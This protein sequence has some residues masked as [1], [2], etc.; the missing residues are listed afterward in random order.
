MSQ[1]I[2]LLNPAFRKVF[3]WLTAT[4][5]A[6]ATGLLLVI[7]GGATALATMRA[8]RQEQA[9]SERAKT[10]KDTQDRLVA[11]GKAVA[12]SKPNAELANELSSTLAFLKSREE[13]MKV[14]E[15]G[16][17]GSTTGFTEFLRGF[18]RQTPTGLWLTGFTIGAAGSDMEIRGRMT[19]P[20][21]LPEYIRRL[22][23]EPVFQGR[24]FASLTIQR[25]AAGKDLKSLESILDAKGKPVNP[26]SPADKEA[27]PSFVEFVLMP[28]ASDPFAALATIVPPSKPTPSTS[29]QKQGFV[30][31]VLTPKTE[32]LGKAAM[33]ELKKGNDETA[34]AHAEALKKLQ[35]FMPSEKKP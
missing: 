21:A 31:P 5:L 30:D 24:R 15:G 22:K 9:A 3:D 17:I 6:I 35:D 11:M 23:T 25:P 28:E 10:L 34:K 29:P 32:N 8:D 13:I 14:L 19:N 33:E 26:A 12:E 7:L 1:Q 16:A 18:A 27:P 20:A 4:P 2:N